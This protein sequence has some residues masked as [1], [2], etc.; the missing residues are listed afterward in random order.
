MSVDEAKDW[1]CQ[2][3]NIDKGLENENTDGSM[4]KKICQSN[5]PPKKRLKTRE[6]SSRMIMTHSSDPSL[7]HS[8]K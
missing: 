8:W 7:V 2:K 1:C 4:S 5:L 3:C 6:L